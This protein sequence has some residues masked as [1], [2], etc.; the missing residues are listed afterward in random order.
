MDIYAFIQQTQ[1]KMNQ[2]ENR[3]QTLESTVQSMQQELTELQS[4]SSIHID[5]IEYKFDQLKVETLEGTL[6]IGLNPFNGEQIE[7]FALGQN[8]VNVNKVDSPPSAPVPN[9][10]ENIANQMHNYV[11]TYGFKRLKDIETETRTSLDDEQRAMMVD[12]I[13]SQIEPRLPYYLSMINQFPAASI[14][15]LN[16]VRDTIVQRMKHDIDM[17]FISYI[18]QQYPDAVIPP[19][20]QPETQTVTSLREGKEIKTNEFYSS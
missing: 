12:D 20:P 9:L 17:A 4:K 3:V 2:L 14:G 19:T 5:R 18:Q 16:N 11:D 10:Y 6:N 15:D 8:G 13:R 7:D 1:L